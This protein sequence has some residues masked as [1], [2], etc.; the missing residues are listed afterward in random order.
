MIFPI[1]IK[2]LNL[3]SSKIYSSQA[4]SDSRCS[5]SII[6]FSE[7]TSPNIS[8]AKLIPDFEKCN[9]IWKL[10]TKKLLNGAKLTNFLL[11]EID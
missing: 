10:T 9:P 8:A 7:S 5:H 2:K 6:D 1:L 11:F 3:S 4:Y